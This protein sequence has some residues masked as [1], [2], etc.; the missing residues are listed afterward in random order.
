MAFKPGTY[1]GEYDDVLALF[2]IR[3]AIHSG[4]TGLPHRVSGAP[5]G[6]WHP[7]A[8]G[9]KAGMSATLL[10]RQVEAEGGYAILE[11]NFNTSLENAAY[12]FFDVPGET[13]GTRI[14]SF[15]TMINLFKMSVKMGD[16]EVLNLDKTREKMEK[17]YSERTEIELQHAQRRKE[18]NIELQDI[19]RRMTELYVEYHG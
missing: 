11:I 3:N 14:E 10:K 7:G 6:V 5:E 4:E 18:I 16:I 9:W 8:V 12:S 17:Y 2:G 19:E 1:K 13:A 15:R